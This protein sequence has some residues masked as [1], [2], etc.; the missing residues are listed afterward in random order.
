MLSDVEYLQRFKVLDENSE[1]KISKVFFA[2]IFYYKFCSQIKYSRKLENWCFLLA[3]ENCYSPLWL[4]MHF[5]IC[6]KIHTLYAH[7]SSNCDVLWHLRGLS[8]RPMPIGASCSIHGSKIVDDIS[9]WACHY[10][11]PFIHNCRRVS[12]L[13]NCRRVSELK[14][15]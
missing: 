10:T 5:I 12:E 9:L 3:Q 4:W 6:M 8:I 2:T 14:N 7:T 13:K 11:E 1:K 15:H